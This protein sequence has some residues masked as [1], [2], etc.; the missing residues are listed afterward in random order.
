[1]KN[2][3]LRVVVS[4]GGTGGHIFPAVAIA[5]EIKQRYPSAEIMFVGASGRMEMEKVPA[6]GYNIV[7]LPIVGY[8]RGKIWANVLLIPKLIISMIKAFIFI[9]R[10]KPSVVI[11][12][13]GYASAPVLKTAAMRG[14]KTYI[15]E[16]NSY[17]GLTNRRLSATAD[18]IFVAYPDMERFFP[19]DKVIYTGNPIRKGLDSIEELKCSSYEHFKLDSQK[20]TILI[21]GG[22]LGARTLNDGV[23]AEIDMIT[24]R[25]DIQ[26]IWQTGSYYY[27]GIIERLGSRFGSNMLVVKFISDMHRAYAIADLVIS[28]AGASSVS[29]LAVTGKPIILVPSPNVAEDHQTMNAEALKI[30]G[31]AIVLTDQTILEKKQMLSV[32]VNTV[33]NKDKLSSL[34]RNISSFA[35]KN[36]ASDIVDNIFEK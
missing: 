15:Q 32:A 19:A 34:S 17:A 29:E 22:S 1:M 5:D 21:I 33:L 23:E 10:F 9:S 31:A 4:G 27:D 14:I 13:G 20:K 6:S 35:K 25:D 3:I 18:K 36:A 11:G 2:E 28:R 30:K 7:G 12:T 24:Q 16:Q 26:I 8:Q